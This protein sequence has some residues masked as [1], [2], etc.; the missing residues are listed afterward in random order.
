LEKA[1]ITEVC[2]RYGWKSVERSPSLFLIEMLYSQND[3]KSICGFAGNANQKLPKLQR[4]HK[5]EVQ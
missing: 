4:K 2:S 3:N 1:C 5:F